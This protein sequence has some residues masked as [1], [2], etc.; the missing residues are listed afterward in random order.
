L[1]ALWQARRVA[2]VSHGVLLG[3]MVL[4]LVVIVVAAVT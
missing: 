1:S 2:A 3:I 4:A